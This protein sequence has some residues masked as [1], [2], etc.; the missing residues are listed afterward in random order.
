MKVDE[1]EKQVPQEGGS[2]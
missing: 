2:L 1:G